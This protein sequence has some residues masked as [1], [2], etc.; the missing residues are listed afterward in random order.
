MKR[1][2]KRMCSSKKVTAGTLAAIMLGGVCLAG[3]DEVLLP[4]SSDAHILSVAGDG[5]GDQLS[6][7]EEVA[8]GYDYHSADQNWNDLGD[9]SDLAMVCRKVI[10]KLPEGDPNGKT[11]EVH[12]ITHAMRGLV[13]CGGCGET[14]NMGT[15]DIVNPA[16]DLSV[17]IPILSLHTMEHGSFSYTS[18]LHRGRV[19]VPLLVRILELHYPEEPNEHQLVP[20]PIDLDN[21]FITDAEELGLGLNP[22]ECDQNRNLTTDGVELARICAQAIED[23]PTYNG[24]DDLGIVPTTPYKIFMAMLGLESCDICGQTMNMGFYEVINPTL[25][26]STQVPVMAVHN[27]QHGCFDYSGSTNQGRVELVS[28][29]KILEM[30]ETCGD[31]KPP[32]DVN[33]PEWPPVW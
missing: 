31:L 1:V 24:W 28:L 16:L 5:D 4:T 19:D 10:G 27:M 18:D 11:R 3:A 8:L 33:E 26:T 25:G 6:M 14:I 15:V 2:R 13:T 12:R 9:G 21:D 22:Y 23:L 30:D 32:T 20:E 29:L 17:N 7:A